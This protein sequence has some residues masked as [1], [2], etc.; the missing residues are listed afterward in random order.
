MRWPNLQNMTDYDLR[1]I[2]KYLSAIHCITGDP[3]PAE[4]ASNWDEMPV[5]DE[6]QTPP[7]A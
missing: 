5:V 4:P 1:A 2:Y 3:W 7:F 6:G